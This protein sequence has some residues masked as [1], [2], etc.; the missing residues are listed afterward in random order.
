MILTPQLDPSGP[1]LTL[2]EAA[3]ILGFSERTM[4]RYL[5]EHQF[6]GAWQPKDGAPWRFPQAGLIQYIEEHTDVPD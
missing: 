1:D 2:D 6:P 4:R 3:E 5:S